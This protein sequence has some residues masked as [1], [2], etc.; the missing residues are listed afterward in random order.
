MFLEKGT[1]EQNLATRAATIAFALSKRE[2]VY[3]LLLAEIG[4]DEAAQFA[5]RLASAKLGIFHGA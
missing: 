5:L 4:A 2:R 3:N 1:L